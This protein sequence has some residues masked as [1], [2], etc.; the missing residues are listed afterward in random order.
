[1]GLLEAFSTCMKK[2]AVFEGRARRSE[3]WNFFLF[4][5]IVS[6]LISVPAFYGLS[7][8]VPVVV[9]LYGVSVVYSRFIFLPN[10]A[11]TVRRL[12]D[13]G[14]SGAH[15]FLVLIPV[16]GA[17]ILLIY[18]CRDSDPGDNQYGPNPK[19]A[20]YVPV[21]S[22]YIPPRE[23]TG[24]TVYAPTVGYPMSEIQPRLPEAKKLRISFKDG[25]SSGAFAEGKS[26]RIGRDAHQCQLTIP[27]VPGVSRAHCVVRTDG[28]RIEVRDLHSSYGTFLSDG[29]RLDPDKP[30]T[31][32]SGAHIYLG[33]K[34]AVVSVKLI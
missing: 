26:L 34:H 28:K 17:V 30:V 21:R 3:Y 10:L 16:I 12:H 27:N 5:Y 33:S 9:R 29:T 2:Y 24:A 11:V 25:Q 32:Q 15:Y 23:F 31:V 7:R 22:S 14:H 20:G 18:L 19:N 13:T 1:M 8:S 4:N 6:A